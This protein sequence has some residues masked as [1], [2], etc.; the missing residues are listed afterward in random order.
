MDL[1]ACDSISKGT[2]KQKM[3]MKQMDFEK[4]MALE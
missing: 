4:F 2:A 1:M 3:K